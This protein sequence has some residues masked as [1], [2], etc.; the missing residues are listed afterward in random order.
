MSS[1]GSP[2]GLGL[3][4]GAKFAEA[5]YWSRERLEAELAAY[6]GAELEGLDFFD[7]GGTQGYIAVFDCLVVLAF[8]GTEASDPRDLY[9]DLNFRKVFDPV[10]GAAVSAGFVGAL[11]HVWPGILDALAWRLAGRR[12]VILGHSL[13]GALATLAAARLAGRLAGLELVTY[14]APRAGGASLV[15]VLARLDRWLRVVN[16]VDL[17]TRLAPWVFGHRHGG[18]LRYI[19][20][21][22]ALMRGASPLTIACDRLLGAGFSPRRWLAAGAADHSISRYRA[23]LAA[24]ELRAEFDG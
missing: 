18:D 12:L 1:P 2:R 5:A 10:S 21:A 9:A 22:G 13:G 20:A 7:A 11:D 24:I 19:N 8:R 15:R 17:V 6:S 14:G 23:R 16:G 3:A 4:A